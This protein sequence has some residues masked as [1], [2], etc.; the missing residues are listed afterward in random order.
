V[1]YSYLIEAEEKIFALE[2]LL[3][4]ART[5]IEYGKEYI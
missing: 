2:E 4:M 3:E 5:C 1:K